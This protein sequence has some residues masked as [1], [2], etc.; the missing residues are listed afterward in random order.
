MKLRSLSI[1]FIFNVLS[2]LM[3]IVTLP[4][5]TRYMTP[6]DYGTW[7][8]FSLMTIY[9]SAVSRW[10]IN[11]ALKVKFVNAEIDFSLYSSTAFFFACGWFALFFL[12]WLVTLPWNPGWN[13]VSG[14]W[15]IALGSLAF[16][17]YQTINLHQLLQLESRSFLYGLWSFLANLGLY[18]VAILLLMFADMDWRARAWAELLVAAISFLW[19]LEFWRKDY[20]LRWRFDVRVLY[21]ML[22][23]SSPLMLSSL[24]SYLLTTVDRLFIAQM[25]GAEQLGLYTIAVQLSASMGLFMSAVAPAWE[26]GLYNYQGSLAVHIRRRLRLFAMVVLLTA[27]VLMVLPALL[28]WVLPLLT[29]KSFNSAQV[30]LFP[31]LLVAA[32]TGLFVLLQPIAVLLNRTRF[33]AILNLCMF[34]VACAGMLWCIPLFGG[35]AAAYSLAATYLCGGAALIVLILRWTADA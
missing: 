28:E 27:G 1:Y 33:F 13:G 18:G 34:A 21:E 12:L 17:R 10:E 26:A 14:I 25:L 30:Y 19:A 35:P 24:I 20:G 22:I 7:T 31:A 3:P 11:N 5:F 16:F 8:V 29:H 9:V 15:F 4:F 6:Q 32:C 23:F 2:A